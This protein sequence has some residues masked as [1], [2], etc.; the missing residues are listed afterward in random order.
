MSSNA[1]RSAAAATVP[2]SAAGAVDSGAG[3]G[4]AAGGAGAGADASIMAASPV[5]QASQRSR[6]SSSS[7]APAMPAMEPDGDDA[8]WHFV[9]P[10]ERITFAD[11]PEAER[12]RLRLDEPDVFVFQADDGSPPEA[13]AH[14]D[15][16]ATDAQHPHG[17]DDLK[18][19]ICVKRFMGVHKAAGVGS[20]ALRNALVALAAAMPWIVVIDIPRRPSARLR[21]V[22]TVLRTIFVHEREGDKSP[23]N[24]AA[25]LWTQHEW[26]ALNDERD[27]AARTE[28]DKVAARHLDTARDDGV[29]PESYVSVLREKISECMAY[30]RQTNEYE[31][32]YAARLDAGWRLTTAFVVTAEGMPFVF[33]TGSMSA[34]L[35][36][37]DGLAARLTRC[38]LDDAGELEMRTCV[39]TAYAWMHEKGAV[40]GG[41]DVPSGDGVRF[42]LLWKD[43]AAVLAVLGGDGDDFRWIGQPSDVEQ[44]KIRVQARASAAVERTRNAAVV[45]NGADALTQQR[46]E[47][48]A[49]DGGGAARRRARAM[50]ACRS[51]RALPRRTWTRQGRAADGE[52]TW[53]P[54][55]RVKASSAGNTWNPAMGV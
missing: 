8:D 51:A 5:S 45:A 6:R 40:Q 30:M 10:S 34:D 16:W 29:A 49:G 33:P 54:K 22:E 9:R 11:V 50:R 3:A 23:L 46:C 31:F 21:L 18:E 25:G 37:I 36:A 17:P 14:V 15:L 12:L 39:S 44:F 24:P 47:R 42:V 20:T 1:G 43:C 35:R 32:K 41:P 26:V 55:G 38:G 13:A 4:A 48:D 53:N 28:L 27:Q 7:A 19:L 2:P 52:D